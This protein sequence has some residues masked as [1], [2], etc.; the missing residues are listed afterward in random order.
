MIFRLQEEKY[1][2]PLLNHR[3]IEEYCDH[4]F[5]V[6]A[7]K[8]HALRSFERAI[9]T[10]RR[11]LSAKDYYPQNPKA[12]EGFTR[13]LLLLTKGGAEVPAASVGRE[14]GAV[15]S[16]SDVKGYGFIQ[17]QRSGQVFV[18][19]SD[20]RGKGFRWL[21]PKQCVEFAVLN[22]N[23]GRPEAKDVE[24]LSTDPKE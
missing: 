11:A 10:I 15:K 22:S 14:R 9:A 17:G 7:D 20:I 8:T 12:L 19:Y 1:N 13:E 6:L 21:E 3:K 23:K 5:G 24:I 4:L 18:H 2:L 16:F